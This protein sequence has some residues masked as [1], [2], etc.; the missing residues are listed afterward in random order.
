MNS[1]GLQSEEYYK[2]LLLRSN[3]NLKGLNA[4]IVYTHR[5]ALVFHHRKN[6]AVC[7]VWFYRLNRAYYI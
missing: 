1:C 6:A 2:T 5:C 7:F 4:A 3:S